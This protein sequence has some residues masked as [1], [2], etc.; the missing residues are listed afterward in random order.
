MKRKNFLRKISLLSLTPILLTE[1]LKAST[2]PPS[3]NSSTVGITDECIL[4]V[5]VFQNHHQK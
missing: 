2:E 5:R 3:T 1:T 4:V